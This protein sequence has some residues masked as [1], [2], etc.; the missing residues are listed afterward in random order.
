MDRERY[1]NELEGEHS[2]IKRLFKEI[3]QTVERKDPRD[4]GWL[5]EKVNELKMLLLGHVYREDEMLYKDLREE[6]VKLEQ[7]ALLPALDVF[8]KSMGDISAEAMDFFNKYGAAEKIRENF[9]GF[10][11][12]FA[13]L[14]EV[15]EKRVTSEEGSLFCIYRAYYHL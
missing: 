6:A 12:E 13:R 11:S 15:I 7:D 4:I 1:L 3:N 9:D 2:M 10:A 14:Y 5:A 8:M